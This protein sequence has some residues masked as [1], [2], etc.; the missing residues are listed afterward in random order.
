VAAIAPAALHAASRLAARAVA[1]VSSTARIALAGIADSLSRTGVAVAALAMAVAAMIG[2]AIM[3][4]SFRESLRSWLER[5]LRADFYVSAPGPGFARPERKL[6]PAAIEALLAVRGVADHSEGRRI[7]VESQRGP[8]VLD[9]VSL[10]RSVG[11]AYELTAGD[12]DRVWKAYARGNLVI[13]EPL[14]W[15]LAL[16]PGE[17]L[18]LITPQGARAFEIAGVYREYGNDR[19]NALLSREVYRRLWHDDAVTVLGLYL[20]RTSDPRAVGAALAV[21]SKS[22]QA[23]FIRSNRELRELSM[24]IFDRTF[25]ITRVL[26]WLAAGVAAIAL[27]SAL[28]AWQLER[29]RELAILRSLGLTPRGAAG[30]IESQTLFMGLATFLAAVPAGYLTALLLIDVINRRAFGWRIELHVAASQFATALSLALA[31]AAIAGI[32]PA[33]RAARAPIATEMREE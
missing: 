32:Y 12:P 14:A 13:S 28:L 1:P 30:L 23:L 10:A 11:P 6:D 25:V 8:I 19:G 15:R 21:A 4:G 17:R 29:G 16:G 31:A 2:V 3:V 27:T 24:S 9:A 22:R 26:N 5:S 7:T 18:T 33:W 20:A